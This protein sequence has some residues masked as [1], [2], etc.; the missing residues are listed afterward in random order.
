MAVG[1]FVLV[2]IKVW[3]AIR[4]SVGTIVWVG[5]KVTVEVAVIVGVCVANGVAVGCKR[6]PSMILEAWPR[7]TS[8]FG[9]NVPSE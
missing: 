6:A 8:V 7:V 9:L 1:V 4:V 2:G 5:V 3:V